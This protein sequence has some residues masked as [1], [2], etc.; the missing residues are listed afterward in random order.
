MRAI[1]VQRRG[2]PEVLEAADV[3]APS[4]GP[5]Q[6]LVDVAASGVNYIDT[7]H[8][9]GLYKVTLPLCPGVE[10]A[11]TIAEVG[12]GVTGLA[13][14]DRVGWVAASGSYAQKVLV[15]AERAIPLPA[16]VPD[17]VAAA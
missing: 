17:D 4:P 7:Y 9:S 2:G 11:G 14:G 12:E 5:G 6:V 16:G 1:Q 8:R 15:E 13:A 10:G 3:D